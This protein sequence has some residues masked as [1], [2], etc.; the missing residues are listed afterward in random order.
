MLQQKHF[1]KICWSNHVISLAFNFPCL[2]IGFR[3]TNLLPWPTRSHLI[4]LDSS[5]T[6]LPFCILLVPTSSFPHAGFIFLPGMYS[7]ALAL[8]LSLLTFYEKKSKGWVEMNWTNI[9]FPGMS[10]LIPLPTRSRSP[11]FVIAWSLK[12]HAVSL[13]VLPS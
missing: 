4:Y 13:G 3:I 2:T 5:C 1:L 9:N 6:T 7:L 11:S 8:D 10:P 12:N